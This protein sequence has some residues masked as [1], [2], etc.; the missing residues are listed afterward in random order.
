LSPVILLSYG[1]LGY[2]NIHGKIAVGVGENFYV[3]V[4]FA[5]IK[6]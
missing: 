4:S 1:A 5:E 6:P 2:L 3:A